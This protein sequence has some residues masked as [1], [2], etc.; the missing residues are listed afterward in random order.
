MTLQLS[1]FSTGRGPGSRG[2]LARVLKA[3]DTGKLDARIQLVFSNRERG[4]GEGS[5]AFFDL[6]ERRGIPLVTHSSRSFRRAH[7]GDLD[8][9]RSEYDTEVRDLLA[10][11]KPD[12]CVMAGYM[13]VLSPVLCNALTAIR[14]H[15]KIQKGRPEGYQNEVPIT[16][17][18]DTESCTLE[19]NGRIDG[20]FDAS[21]QT[22]IDEIKTTVGDLEIVSTRPNACHWGQAKTYA[23]FYAFRHKLASA[24]YIIK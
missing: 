19:V 9:H 6:V 17:T 4:E 7:G 10:P 24:P 15:Q 11:H 3:I 2:M 18:Y 20:I 13:L 1:W 22:T 21:G 16:R 12:L 8:A 23:C 5:D 14:I